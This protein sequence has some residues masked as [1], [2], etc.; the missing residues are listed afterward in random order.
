MSA[1]IMVRR[2]KSGIFLLVLATCGLPSA[3][4]EPVRTGSGRQPVI[5]E[6]FTSEGCSSCPPADAIL[7][8]LESEQPVEKAEIIVLGEH[9]DYWNY[10]GWTDRFSSA[11]FSE[12]QTEYARQFRLDSIY[13]P[14]MVVDGK[15]ELNGTDEASAKRM[16]SK[17]ATTAKSQLAIRILSSGPRSS[18]LS[19]EIIGSTSGKLGT[20]PRLMLALTERE[21]ETQVKRGE[22]GGR[23]L[24]HT[25]VVRM[26]KQVKQID[27][28]ELEFRVNTTLRIEK[29]WQR[30]H[31]RV[32]AFLQERDGDVLAAESAAL[33]D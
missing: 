32:I 23:T 27:L 6:L 26:L 13:T 14:Q 12:R 18:D 10:I 5:V 2:V 7:R 30:K 9:V 1:E 22:N 15:I 24:R 3:G 21:L 20:K 33:P 29:A 16:I 17:A 31:L 8:K 19:V 25:G 11:A 4:Q 28:H